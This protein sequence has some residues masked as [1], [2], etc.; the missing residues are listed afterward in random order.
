MGSQQ[1]LV[2]QNVYQAEN[3]MVCYVYEKQ[4]NVGKFSTLMMSAN[5]ISKRFFSATPK[6]F[7]DKLFVVIILLT[8]HRNTDVNNPEIPFEFSQEN[9]KRAK[10]IISRYPKQYK[11]GACMPLLDLG[12]RQNGFTSISVMNYVAKLLEMAPMRVYEVA[13]FYTM[14][15]R[16]QDLTKGILLENIFY[17]YVPQHLVNF[18]D[19]PILSRPLKKNWEFMLEKLP[20]TICLL[21]QKLNVLEHV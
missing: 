1:I 21:Q 14:Y 13:T 6:R 8:Q 3:R 19:L 18:V 17:K 12:Q 10:E 9:M 2:S 20:R 4:Q 11:K 15:N 7:S 16:Y 5:S